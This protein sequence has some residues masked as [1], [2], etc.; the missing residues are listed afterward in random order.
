MRKALLAVLVLGLCLVGSAFAADNI[1][2]IGSNKNLDSAV[3]IGS[4]GGNAADVNDSGAVQVADIAMHKD[5]VVGSGSIHVGPC[6]VHTITLYSDTAGDM[7]GIRDYDGTSADW[8]N[9]LEFEIAIAANTSSTTIDLKGAYFEHGLY[10]S[11]SDT[12]N[13]VTGAVYDY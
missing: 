12:T 13:S 2:D 10:I 5:S 4:I 3:L 11:A 7:I 6:Y 1:Q 9:W 8:T